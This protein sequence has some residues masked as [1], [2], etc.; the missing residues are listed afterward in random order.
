MNI[1]T[2]ERVEQKLGT[3]LNETFRH[4]H[5]NPELSGNEFATQAFLKRELDRLGIPYKEMAGTGLCAELAGSRPGR[6]I[7][8]RADIDALPIGEAT[9]LAYASVNDG[10]MHAC[11]HDAHTTAVLGTAA[12]L[13]ARRDEWGGTVK[14]MF[15][16]SEEKHPGGAKPMIDEGL[17]ADPPVD[18]A[19][20]IHTNPYLAPGTFGLKDGS[21]L[22]N[23]DR[24]YIHLIGR[25]G[26]AAAPHEGA[27][28]IAMAGQLIVSMQN[29]VARQVSPF[30]NAVV[31]IGEIRGGYAPNTLADR[32]YLAG[33]VRTMN[34]DTQTMI[35]TKIGKLLQGVADLWGGTFTYDYVRGYPITWN[36][37][38][39]TDLVRQAAEQ[40]LGKES[41]IE[42]PHGYMS[43]DDFAYIARAVPSVFIEW[44]TGEWSEEARKT[45]VP[46]HN[47]KFKV[48]PD[49]LKYGVAVVT[50]SILNYLQGGE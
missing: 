43:A 37:K 23:A 18:A 44:G 42:L 20:G 50:Q 15:Q 14:L 38:A 13:L 22:A 32:V 45:A 33:T 1:V 35:E 30:D 3:Y 19:I 24:F 21:I 34:A 12:M 6:T 46:W 5:R 8:L 31:T 10:A 16:P 40:C 41:V 2:A 36:D 49:A 17:L 7:L 11:G 25:G 48:N 28:A 29:L 27:D 39:M 9:D 4:L 47:P 26:H